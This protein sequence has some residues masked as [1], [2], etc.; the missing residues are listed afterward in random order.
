M[1]T[2]LCYAPPKLG[3]TE[4]LEKVEEKKDARTIS[5]GVAGPMNSKLGY[6]SVAFGSWS[7]IMA[8]SET[9]L[10]GLSYDG[11]ALPQAAVGTVIGD[12]TDRFWNNIFVLICKVDDQKVA[13]RP[14]DRSIDSLPG[15]H[16]FLLVYH[17][18]TIHRAVELTFAVDAGHRYLITS[19]KKKVMEADFDTSASLWVED[20]ATSE[21][22]MD[23]KFSSLKSSYACF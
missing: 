11:P 13:A 10:E 17:G 1:G 9:R 12:S 16:R 22:L 20:I 6:L 18:G 8:C 19:D 7:L 5:R 23:V 2:I 14:T 4:A 3:S 21:R 15:E